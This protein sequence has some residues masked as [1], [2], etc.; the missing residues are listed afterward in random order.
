MIQDGDRVPRKTLKGIGRFFGLVALP[1][2]ALI[3]DEDTVTLRNV[4]SDR[5]PEVMVASAY[6]D[7]VKR[8]PF[9]V[10]S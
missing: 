5:V 3:V 10:S 4:T 9:P 7:Q 6:R 2:A 1:G 8:L